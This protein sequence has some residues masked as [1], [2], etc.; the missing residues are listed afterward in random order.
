M[1]QQ[2]PPAEAAESLSELAY[3]EKLGTKSDENNEFKNWKRSL[4]QTE[5]CDNLGRS[6]ERHGHFY[7][8]FSETGL[9]I[10]DKKWYS[11]C[12]EGLRCRKSRSNNGSTC[13]SLD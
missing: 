10:C 9:N 7:W 3:N 4:N 5:I 8:V 11:P 2:L 1:Y 6:S 13:K 12:W